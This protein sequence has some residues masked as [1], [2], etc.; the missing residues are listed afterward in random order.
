MVLSL[1]KAK[2]YLNDHLTREYSES[3]KA[4]LK[5]G[6]DLIKQY[7]EINSKEKRSKKNKR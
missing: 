2:T 5:L 1:S 3:I 7:K 4:G 6:S